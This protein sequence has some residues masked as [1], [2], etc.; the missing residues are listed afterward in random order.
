MKI[1]FILDQ[2][3]AG[4]GGEEHSNQALG[5]KRIPM[6][7]VTMFNKQL[8][9]Y[10]GQVEA[11]LFSGDGFFHQDAQTNA[12]KMAGMVKKLQ[13]DVVV[14]GPCFH[15]KNYASMAATIAQT[16]EERVGIPTVTTM[17]Q[18]CDQVIN[19]FKDTINIVKMPKKGEVGLNEALDNILHLAQLKANKQ[20]TSEFVAAHCY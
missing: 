6:G 11:T 18:E 5:G 15:Y 2:I 9:K 7:S 1:V 16:I 19:D 12:L 4:L 17:A 14:C 20:D 10:Q 3:Q 8:D 13:P